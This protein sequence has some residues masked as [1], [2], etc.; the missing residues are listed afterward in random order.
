[1][2]GV[3]QH[4][5]FDTVC[6]FESYYT[7]GNINVISQKIN[8][9]AMH[10]LLQ[11]HFE[12][13]G[14][15]NV[16]KNTLKAIDIL[17]RGSVFRSIRR[18]SGD[19]TQQGT[20]LGRKKTNELTNP[21]V[22]AS[23]RGSV[24]S[25]FYGSGFLVPGSSEF[26]NHRPS[27]FRTNPLSSTPNSRH[28]SVMQGHGEA[29]L[30][31]HGSFAHNESQDHEENISPVLKPSRFSYLHAQ[32]PT[33]KQESN[34]VRNAQKETL[35]EKLTKP[36]LGSG[37]SN[38]LGNPSSSSLH[39]RRNSG[40]RDSVS[41]SSAVGIQA[42]SSQMDNTPS[43]KPPEKGR[44]NRTPGKGPRSMARQDSIGTEPN[45]EQ[46]ALAGANSILTF[47]QKYSDDAASSLHEGSKEILK[48]LWQAMD[49]LSK[50]NKAK[51]GENGRYRRSNSV[52]AQSQVEKLLEEFGLRGVL[53]EFLKLSSNSSFF[54][55]PRF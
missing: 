22:S 52:G 47:Q 53:Q 15:G 44:H 24:L 27:V 26:P 38:F 4:I 34:N 9:P 11:R 29:S 54:V 23:K 6:N 17:S 13:K 18:E 37:Q 25:G 16:Q 51:R 10:L 40:S 21:D 31:S 49:R 1:M 48:H 42:S 36:G 2:G 35:E 50:T 41:S 45:N 43:F 55:E 28:G 19:T 5:I 14:R 3:H 20:K 46:P 7:H 8:I 32:S 39:M 12:K 30:I 33:K